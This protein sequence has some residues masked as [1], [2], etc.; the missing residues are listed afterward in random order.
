MTEHIVSAFENELK[1]LAQ[2]VA[3][4]GGLTEKQ[5]VGAIDALIRGDVALASTVR[6]ADP[7]IDAMQREI[8]EAGILVIAK[9][10]PMAID[11][12]EIVAALRIAADLERI[13]DLA[14][15]IAKRVIAINGSLPLP[16]VTG[17]FDAMARLALERIKEVLDAF[18][19]RDVAAAL[20]V[21]KSDG[22]I[23]ALYNSLFREL[24]T[25][26]LEDP[27]NIG[28]CTHLLFCAKN[29]ERIGDHATNIA[30][31]IY[32]VVNGTTLAEERPKLDTTSIV[33]A[34]S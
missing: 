7:A 4:M 20:E 26:M 17:G 10:Q 9:R 1:G 30:E 18:A 16:K 8:E 6:A 31:T 21:W 13:A 12:R 2:R 29:L 28:A 34:G 27:R 32:Y 33:S 3:E 11:L 24:L 22:D 14:K 19:Q 15:N 23:D 5:I 25:Y